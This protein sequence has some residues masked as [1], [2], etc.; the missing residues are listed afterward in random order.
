MKTKEIKPLMER[1]DE[2]KGDD[3][4]WVNITEI[5]VPTQ[6]DKEQLLLAIRYLHDS[7]EIDTDYLGVNTL[8]HQYEDPDVI[9]VRA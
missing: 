1:Y 5:V 4:K 8:V 6:Y 3:Q 2:S 7:R 9:K